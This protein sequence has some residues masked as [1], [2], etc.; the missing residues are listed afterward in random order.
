MNVLAEER[1]RRL[2]D[3]RLGNGERLF[4][5]G[6]MSTRL[7]QAFKVR[8]VHSSLTLWTDPGGATEKKALDA[9]K[10]FSDGIVHANANDVLMRSA[11]VCSKLREISDGSESV[12][13]YGM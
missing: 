8:Y 2:R 7:R 11:F 4:S 10:C 1:K 3:D 5:I 13:K 9:E 6:N 12:V